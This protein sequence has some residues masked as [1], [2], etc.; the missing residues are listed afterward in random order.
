LKDFFPALLKF[1]SGQKFTIFDSCLCAK[2]WGVSSNTNFEVN[3]SHFPFELIF[4]KIWK[5]FGYQGKEDVA[6][7][8]Q[9]PFKLFTVELKR[10]IHYS[11]I[12]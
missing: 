2:E 3:L 8:F 5:V 9:L 7:V 4:D 1:G 6:N 10:T 12:V 11:T